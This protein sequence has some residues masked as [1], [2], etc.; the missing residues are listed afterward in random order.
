MCVCVCVCVCLLPSV[1][2]FG[3]STGFGSYH[4]VHF[5]CVA[6]FAEFWDED[7]D[8]ATRVE[9]EVIALAQE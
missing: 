9:G 7:P 4:I 3:C 6:R 1:Y 8:G 2:C 5:G